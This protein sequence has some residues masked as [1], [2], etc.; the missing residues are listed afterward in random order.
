MRTIAIATAVS[1]SFIGCAGQDV[2]TDVPDE[3]GV[4]DA[5]ED[6]AKADAESNKTIAEFKTADDGIQRFLDESYGYAVFPAIG[7]GGLIIGGS[8]GDGWVYEQKRLIG[9]SEMAKM[10]VGL[11]AGGQSYAMLLVFK[12][13][14]TMDKFKKGDFELGADLK[15]VVVKQGAATNAGYNSGIAVFA[16]SKGGLMA[17]MSVGGQKFSFDP[18]GD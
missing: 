2:S 4:T 7:Q 17:D 1:L 10:S 14:P 18:I 12:D 9:E 15:A 13:K 3:E 8:G 5:Q 16:H 6:Q 11:Q